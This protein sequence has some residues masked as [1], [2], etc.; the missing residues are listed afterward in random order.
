MEELID[1]VRAREEEGSVEL[2]GVAGRSPA[3]SKDGSEA[4]RASSAERDATNV[5][6]QRTC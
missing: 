4:R 1:E 5:L 6:L 3:S 2:E